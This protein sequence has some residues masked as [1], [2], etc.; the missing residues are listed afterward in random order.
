M[1]FTT[2]LAEF[3]LPGSLKNGRVVTSNQAEVLTYKDLKLEHLR[4]HLDQLNSADAMGS[5]WL[6]RSIIKQLKTLRTKGLVS[7][8][9]N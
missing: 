7:T 3:I 5:G 4:I 8:E 2:S 9:G 1:L 6:S